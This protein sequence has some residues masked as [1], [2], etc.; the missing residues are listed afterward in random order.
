MTAA[1]VNK[2]IRY[3]PDEPCSLSVS[4]GIGVQGVLLVIAPMVVNVAIVFRAS[5][6]P[7]SYISWA[8]FAALVI[9]GITT[10]LQASRFG[11]LGSGHLIITG[12]SP[13]FIAIGIT[14]LAQGGPAMMASLIFA[15]S[16]VPFALAAWLPL[17]RRIITPVVSGTVIMLV[18]ATVVPIAW[19]LLG[20]VP[21]GASSAAA[22][23]ITAVTLAVSTAMALR[24]SGNWQLW[25][26]LIGIVAGCAVTAMFGLYDF[27]RVSEAPWVG[28]PWGEWQGLDLTPSPEFWALLPVFV[29]VTLV[30]TVNSISNG[31]VV[32]TASR[33]Q[34]RATD[35]RLV[36]GTL[37]ANGV[38]V[39]L[40]G[41]A[42]TLPTMAYMGANISLVNL[43]GVAARS[44]GYVIGTIFLGLAFLPKLTALLLA[45]PHPVVGVFL[46]I[47]MA[48]LFVAG[49]RLIFQ[50]GFDIR[51]A[52]IA[53]LAF[54]IGLGAQEQAIFAD[55]LNRLFS[56]LF[57]NGMMVGAL[58]VILLT[59]FIELTSPRPRRLETELNIS[60]LPKIDDFL[61]A[62]ASKITWNEAAT[63]RLRAAG[64]ETLAS[65]LQLDVNHGAD[66][67]RRLNIVAR[68]A[69]GT[70]E[71]EFSAVSDGENLE[72]RLAYLSEHVQ[73]PDESEIS[74]RLLKHYASSVRHRQYFGIDII[75][76]RVEGSR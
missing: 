58:T 65:L 20:D 11:R 29:I 33:R 8:V 19:D 22:P 17:L 50:D 53:G 56:I 28:V 36:Q 34:P 13:I 2:N 71:L 3:E 74:F 35:F 24:A 76:V 5:G 41:V 45:I 47:L 6:Q 12:P 37:N 30:L 21:E 62:L 64:E 43:T 4:I 63:E 49:M 72:D 61:R 15:A 42:G 23:C 55:R 44:V 51:N 26:P 16:I 75:T 69:A 39:L 27:S 52:T 57:S 9:G 66:G 32:Q 68:P 67:P 46:L 48:L 38:G 25:S 40:S 70:V 59:L 60:A 10:A 1:H 7:E 14:A 54:W 73:I 18:A 31:I